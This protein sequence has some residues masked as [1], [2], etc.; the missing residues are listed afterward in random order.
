MVLSSFSKTWPNSSSSVIPYLLP[1]WSEFPDMPQTLLRRVEMTALWV[2]T[3]ITNSTSCSGAQCTSCMSEWQMVCSV[4]SP[5][6]LLGHPQETLVPRATKL[7][8]VRNGPVLVPTRP[9]QQPCYILRKA[10]LVFSPPLKHKTQ[11]LHIQGKLTFLLTCQTGG[12]R[13]GEKAHH[14]HQSHHLRPDLPAHLSQWVIGFSWIEG[15][16]TRTQTF[17]VPAW[18]VHTL[19]PPPLKAAL[20]L[21]MWEV[22]LFLGGI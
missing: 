11:L 12:W 3:E 14:C 16:S 9:H 20:Q 22:L 5:L 2:R 8:R 13:N 7:C 17:S 6:R 15:Q 10:G 4:L 18:N 19:P 21:T 1:R